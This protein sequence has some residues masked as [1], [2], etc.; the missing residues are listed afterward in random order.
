[1][2]A[3]KAMT[4]TVARPVIVRATGFGELSLPLSFISVERPSSLSRRFRLPVFDAHRQFVFVAEITGADHERQ[5]QSTGDG[6]HELPIDPLH[7]R[8]VRYSSVT[9]PSEAFFTLLMYLYS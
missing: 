2:A 3:K 7:A 8:D 6:D 1:M 5:P 4:A 9:Q